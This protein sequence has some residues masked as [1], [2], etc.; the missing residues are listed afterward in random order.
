M[1]VSKEAEVNRPCNE[2]EFNIRKHIYEMGKDLHA[3]LI[4]IEKKLRGLKMEGLAK[5]TV[6][7]EDVEVQTEESK[8]NNQ[9]GNLKLISKLNE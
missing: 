3:T 2:K 5:D 8:G 1:L 7:K 9:Q 4:Q 6:Q